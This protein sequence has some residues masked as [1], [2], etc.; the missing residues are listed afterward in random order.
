MVHGH[1]EVLRGVDEQHQR[2]QDGIEGER[3]HVG[4]EHAHAEEEDVEVRLVQRRQRALGDRHPR[5]SPQLHRPA[6][7]S[8]LLLAVR[9]VVRRDLVRALDVVPPHE[10]PA[11]EEGAERE[12]H[13]LHQRACVPPAGGVDARLAPHAAGAVEVEEVARGEARVLLA[14]DVR[15]QA[16]L[17]VPAEERFV[18]VLVRPTALHEAD[19]PILKDGDGT[20]QEVSLRQEV[21]VEDGDEL[22][23]DVVVHLVHRACLVALPVGAAYHLDLNPL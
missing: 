15:V 7:P 6:A 1:L 18:G 12:V 17:L 11:L 21:R 23:F 9:L 8:S 14:L 13:V 4:R 3:D 2:H 22:C 10:L 5:R 16:D 20:Q 19:V